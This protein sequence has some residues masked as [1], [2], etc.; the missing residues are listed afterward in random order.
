MT[1]ARERTVESPTGRPLEDYAVDVRVEPL[2]S[3]ADDLSSDPALEGTTDDKSSV[4]ETE[5]V[6]DSTTC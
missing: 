1:L 3:Q 6:N 5:R 2:I 4:W